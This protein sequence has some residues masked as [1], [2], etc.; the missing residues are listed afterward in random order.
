MYEVFVSFLHVPLETTVTSFHFQC[1][2]CHKV[3]H[4][5]AHLKGIN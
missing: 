1:N 4:S 3:C 2:I 5:K